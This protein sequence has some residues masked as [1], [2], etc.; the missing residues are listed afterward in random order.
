MAR[1]FPC[2]WLV[3]GLL[4]APSGSLPHGETSPLA[5]GSMWQSLPYQV[6]RDPSGILIPLMC[7][8]LA[9]YQGESI[10]LVSALLT[11][12]SCSYSSPKQPSRL[13]A[14]AVL[15]VLDHTRVIPLSLNLFRWAVASSNREALSNMSLGPH[16]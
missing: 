11:T 10:T 15:A 6:F 3:V 7:L 12:Y 1:P 5:C 2:K 16:N 9:Y 4:L 13:P 8:F 14:T